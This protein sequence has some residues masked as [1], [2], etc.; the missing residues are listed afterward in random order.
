[1]LTTRTRETDQATRREL[2]RL[3][4]VAERVANLMLQRSDRLDREALE[5]VR[6]MVRM[7]Q[8]GLEEA[9]GYSVDYAEDVA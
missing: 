9:A 7:T 2:R 3:G 1:M 4:I 5:R 8:G 6:G